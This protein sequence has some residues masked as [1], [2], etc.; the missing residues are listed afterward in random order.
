MGYI[1]TKYATRSLSDVLADVKS[2]SHWAKSSDISVDGIFFDE[3]PYIYS[4]ATAKYMRTIDSVAK[5]ADGILGNR[6]VRPPEFPIP[7]G[8]MLT[9]NHQVI[10]NPGVIPDSRYNDTNLDITVV[11]EGTYNAWEERKANVFAMQN[12]RLK[13]SVM[14]NSMPDMNQTALHSFVDSIS[15]VAQYIFI[16]RNSHKV[17]ETF[18]H[19]WKDLPIAMTT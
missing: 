1:R 4:V 9:R 19:S 18:S 12:N 3:A 14:I 16:T 7:V 2:Y 5:S 6:T 11:F 10:H 17:Y 15:S 8:L 13:Q